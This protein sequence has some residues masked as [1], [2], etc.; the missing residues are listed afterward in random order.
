MYRQSGLIEEREK[1]WETFKCMKL[2]RVCTISQELELKV[3][4]PGGRIE[5]MDNC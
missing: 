5:K 4:M 2:I 3:V 1:G